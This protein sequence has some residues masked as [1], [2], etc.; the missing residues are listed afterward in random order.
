MLQLISLHNFLL[1]VTSIESD[2]VLV[3]YMDISN[4]F[5]NKKK[6]QNMVL[7]VPQEKQLK[8]ELGLESAKKRSVHHFEGNLCFRAVLIVIT[9]KFKFLLDRVKLL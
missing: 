3:P 6:Y 9:G 2:K 8:R 1:K 4:M 7:H 5:K